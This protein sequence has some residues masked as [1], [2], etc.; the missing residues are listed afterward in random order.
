M[1]KI[2]IVLMLFASLMQTPCTIPTSN[3]NLQIELK[4]KINKQVV[5]TESA[6]LLTSKIVKKEVK[7][8]KE[9][10]KEVPQ[11]NPVVETKQEVKYKEI[12]IIA[13]AYTSSDEDCGK[14]DGITASGYMAN[15]GV[16]ALPKDMKFG[17][18][19]EIEG[20]GK[21]VGLDR[22]GAIVRI[23]GNTIKVDVWFPTANQAKN[24][25]VKKLK[26]KVLYEP[27]VGLAYNHKHE[28]FAYQ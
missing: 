23:D 3:D 27:K 9:E 20:L 18:V 10:V 8:V 21:K 24:F 28:Y 15:S 2:K 19:L 26:G 25:G 22:G 6:K 17:T 7:E 13:T 5:Q 1:S 14:N 11:S 16:I 4:V 12:N